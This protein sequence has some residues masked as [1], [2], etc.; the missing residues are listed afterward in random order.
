MIDYHLLVQ[1]KMQAKRCPHCW[2]KTSNTGNMTCPPCNNYAWSACMTSDMLSHS[3]FLPPCTH[4]SQ[5]F[6]FSLLPTSE[7]TATWPSNGVTCS[8]LSAEHFCGCV[9][10]IWAGATCFHFLSINLKRLYATL[11][12]FGTCCGSWLFCELIWARLGGLSFWFTV[13][14]CLWI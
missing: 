13:W 10:G 2:D 1:I 9:C 8:S 5:S 14:E 3:A 12:E 7:S 4:G 11:R 6:A